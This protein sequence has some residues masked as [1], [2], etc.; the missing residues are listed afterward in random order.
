M[1]GPTGPAAW[2][3]P[4]SY[5]DAHE[6]RRVV[7]L[8]SRRAVMAAMGLDPDALPDPR[9]A[10]ILARPGERLPLA[11]E[12][13]LED[14]TALGRV[15]ALPPDLPIGYHHLDDR[16]LFVA[17]RRCHLPRGLR[18]WGWVVQLYAARSAGSWGH[19]DFADLRLLGD[20]AR[21]QGAGFVAASPTWAANPGAARPEASPY[22]PS[23]RRFGSP[24]YVRLEAILGAEALGTELVRLSAAG[25][26]LNGST[27]IDR[28]AVQE[29][30]LRGLAAIW[31]ATDRPGIPDAFR[32]AIG[33]SLRRW[34]TFAAI[35][36]WQ[37]V[38]WRSWPVELQ[39]PDG[40]AVRAFA[41][42]S[43]AR[44]AFHEWVQWVIDRQL[45]AAGAAISIVNDLPVGAAPDGFD[46][47]E[48][49]HLLADGATMG[50]P[51]DRFNL[52]GQDWGIPP[53]VPHRLRASGHA[54]FIATVR[55][56][57]RHAGGL[58]L[59][60]VLGLF[61]QWWVPSGVDP[62]L[63]AYVG[64][65]TDELLAVL[66][67]ESARAGA[68]IIG[69]DLG[70]VPR[71]VRTRLARASVLSTRLLYFER[72]PPAAYPRG[73]LAAITTHDLPTM[74]G[75]WSGSDL[76]DQ[77]AAGQPP[78]PAEL[79]GLR[80]RVAAVTGV[81][82]DTATETVV[83]AAHRAL[84][85]APSALV[86]ATLEDAMLVTERPNMPGTVPPARDNWSTALPRSIESL[87]GDPF[88][89][90]LVAALR[91]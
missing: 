71:G 55:A 18:E 47:W 83:L 48:W 89:G 84:A 8:R 44:I 75:L 4:G 39:D 2:G 58:R 19:G 52:A 54:P 81:A 38:G 3:I 7:P 43:A 32:G 21:E 12:L 31:E 68:L 50:V 23:S 10:V 79:D 88:V 73:A 90:Q 85:G 49:R 45:A 74:A 28:A 66:A 40:P 1:P 36:E 70:T 6:R 29:L 60:H 63:G 69:E 20:L 65:P 22:F 37:G 17:P 46:A 33:P 16:H 41:T 56:G 77:V 67:I 86:G 57:L 42:R 26:A 14:G 62:T 72:R 78:D 27:H 9:P 61:R 80:R 82:P 64:F 76:A 5:R 13:S 59:D 11:G 35:S 87:A 34:A 51:P 25:R 24:L 30:K 53:L 15:E 91:R